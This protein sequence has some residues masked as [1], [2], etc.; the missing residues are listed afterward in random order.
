VQTALHFW[1]KADRGCAVPLNFPACPISNYVVSANRVRLLRVLS[2]VP[3]SCVGLLVPSLPSRRCLPL[4]S[5]D[6]QFQRHDKQNGAVLV[7]QL[8]LR[9]KA[10]M[11]LAY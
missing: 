9:G 2:G 5:R 4:V 11:P 8:N 7:R 6:K 3:G 1:R 10:I